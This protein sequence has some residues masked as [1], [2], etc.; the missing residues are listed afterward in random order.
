MNVEETIREYYETLRRGGQLHPYFLEGDST[1]KF[2]VSEAVFGYE[3]VADAL[4]EQAES[5]AEWTVESENLVVDDRDE[6]AI[7]ADEVTLAWTDTQSGQR[8]RFDT[9][10]SGTLERQGLDADQAEWKFRTM[11][12]SAPH[13][14]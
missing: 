3:D 1:T 8:W 13:Q 5:T 6:Y 9:R 12:V 11:H 10:W 4:R 14:L 2:G 7:F